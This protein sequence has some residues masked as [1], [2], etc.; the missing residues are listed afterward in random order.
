MKGRSN[1]AYKK[2]KINVKKD[3]SPNKLI[4][5]ILNDSMGGS[6]KKDGL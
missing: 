3:K 5:M 6:P 2:Q 1:I 4:E